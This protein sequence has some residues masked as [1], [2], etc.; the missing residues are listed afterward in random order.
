LAPITLPAIR[1][2]RRVCSRSSREG[3]QQDARGVGTVDNEVRNPVG[4]RIGFARAGAGNNEK[5]RSYSAAMLHAVFNGTALLRIEFIKI[6]RSCQHESP[7]HSISDSAS[8]D[9]VI[10]ARGPDQCGL[11]LVITPPHHH[12]RGAWPQSS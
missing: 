11:S 5:G 3:H 8:K 9:N 7:R 2:T 12:R 1:V 4:Q 10:T 6:S